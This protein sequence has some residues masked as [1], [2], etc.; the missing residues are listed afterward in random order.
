MATTRKTYPPEYKLDAIRLAKDSGN[1]E[2]TA[3][4]RQITHARHDGIASSALRR[5]ICQQH[6]REAQ[7]QGRPAFTGH[8]NPLSVSR[9]ANSKRYGENSRSPGRSLLR[10]A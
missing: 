10:E 4:N 1:I 2:Q 6:Q 9:N 7:G 5:W 3:R 8:G